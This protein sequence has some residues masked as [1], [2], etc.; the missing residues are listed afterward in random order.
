MKRLICSFDRE[1]A[2]RIIN[3]E[4]KRCPEN[5]II[6]Y[7]DDFYSQYTRIDKETALQLI[8]DNQK[9]KS[10][11]LYADY[12]THEYYIQPHTSDM[13]TK[14]ELTRVCSL[15]KTQAL[16][17]VKNTENSML[18]KIGCYASY[19]LSS[20]DEALNIIENSA[21]GADID[22][23]TNNHFYH[24]CCPTRSDMW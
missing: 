12:E 16:E 24:I 10:V 17:L 21:V 9:M 4:N 18:I 23:D 7:K 22:E 5:K 6:Y 3:F 8:A 1:R 14:P 20:K 2:Y 15:N 13:P 11:I 19:E